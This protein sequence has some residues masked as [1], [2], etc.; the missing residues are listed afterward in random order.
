[1][2]AEGTTTRGHGVDSA[3][4]NRDD[5]GAS[6]SRKTAAG[7]VWMTAQ[8]W[9]TRILGFVTIAVL[10][11][12]LRPE[13]F[14]A[15]AAA[16]TVLPFFNLLSDFGFAA[17]V[18]QATRVDARTLSTNF[19]F[20]MGSGL[21]LGGALF[22]A[23]PMLGGIYGDDRVVPVLQAMALVVPITAS[24]AVSMA[25]L[26]RNMRFKAVAVQ[27]AVAAFI[28]QL[29]A[30]GL[31]VGG[32]G[33]WAL[34]GQTLTGAAVGTVVAWVTAGWHPSFQF[35]GRALRE[36]AVFGGRVLAV[37]FIAFARIW[38]EALIISST[39]GI[40]ALGFIS[41]AQRI[42]AIIQD[43]TGG[44][45][46][47]VSLVAFSKVRGSS[48]RLTAAYVRAV[49]MT[50]AVMAP[51]LALL[52]VCGPLIVPIVFGPGW[53]DSARLA[54]VL[55]VAGIITM[56]ASLDNGLFY[57]AGRPG[58]WL[59]YAVV[60]DGLT[61]TTTWFAAPYGLQAVVWAF[62]GLVVVATVV[63][64]FLV[65]RLLQARPVTT[66]RPFALLL[67]SLA[68]MALAGWLALFATAALPPIIAVA[69]IGLLLVAVQVVVVR[70]VAP[71]VAE[72]A[73]GLLRRV[74]V[75]GARLDR[76][77]GPTARIT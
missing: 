51:P 25:V 70:L 63:R 52:A 73:V 61:V 39:L 26:R 66:A 2:S 72:D 47:P 74:P 71:D 57:G 30:I 21:V 27:G 1:M 8:R 16:L 62:L 53:G 65:A 48:E 60:V 28:A 35:S 42:V 76:W 31:A 33:V 24:G 32:F 64:W 68:A 10:T 6:V 15:V 67:C 69:L 45:V 41:I 18:M 59:V 56:G 9:V 23:A 12:L 77:S 49:R 7:I 54:Q 34:V 17:Y 55:A 43:L 4:E 50:Y 13:D 20:S 58:S 46:I 19:W 3:T 37:E 29:V 36:M 22:A 14:G 5:Q 75:V 11:R 40:A 38:A 44:A